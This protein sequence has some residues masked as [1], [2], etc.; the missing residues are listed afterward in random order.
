MRE[1]RLEALKG[2]E[3]ADIMNNS[4]SKNDFILKTGAL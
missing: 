2:D 1:K 3:I 4:D